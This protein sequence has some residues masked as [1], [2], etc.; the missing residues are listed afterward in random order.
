MAVALVIAINL[1][2]PPSDE[3]QI[4][5]VLERVSTSTDRSYCY[6]TMT[7]AYLKQRSGY[8]NDDDALADCT[9]RA[10]EARGLPDSVTVSEIDVSGDVATAQV[11]YRGGVYDGATL[12]YKLVDDG[13][14]WRL[15]RLLTIQGLDADRY[16]DFLVAALAR[17]PYGWD[18]R[19]AECFAGRVVGGSTAD[20]V[21]SIIDFD[22][23]HFADAA[24]ACDRGAVERLAVATYAS[25]DYDLDPDVVDCVAEEL[26]QISNQELARLYAQPPRQRSLARSCGS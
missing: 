11:A 21:A 4:A 25:D 18:H 14:D 9:Y 22:F 15:D 6:E 2:S 3:R 20:L 16:E 10:D 1:V 24:V 12:H 23:N 17:D 19:S 5:N 26:K 8:A 7:F 13:E